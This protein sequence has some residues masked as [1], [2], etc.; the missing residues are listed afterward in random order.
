[1]SQPVVRRIALAAMQAALVAAGI[2]V[3]LLLFSRPA[4]A[5]TAAL[6]PLTSKQTSTAS[7]ASSTVGP[8]SSVTPVGR[9]FGRRFGR[10]LGHVTGHLGGGFSRRACCFGDQLRNV[11]G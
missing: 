8:A 2:F 5:A 10:R 1:M 9:R 7:T 3:V 11:A 6:A 4:H